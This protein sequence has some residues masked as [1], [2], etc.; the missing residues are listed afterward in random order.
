MTDALQA[1]EGA[2][3]RYYSRKISEF[4][5]TPRGV[6]WN[7]HESQQIRFHQ[8]AKIIG[9]A[10]QE[11]ILLNDLGCGYGAYYDYLNTLGIPLSYRGTDLSAGMIAAARNAHPGADNAQFEVKRTCA[12]LAHYS[13][14]SGVF[15]VRQMASVADW[16]AYVLSMLEELDSNSSRGFAFNCLSIYSDL[17]H[18]RADLYYGDPM[19]FFDHCKRHF[20]K[21]VALLHDYDLY[22]FTVLVRK[23]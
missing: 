15:N 22:E 4:G 21:N 16:H 7:S 11:P 5:A 19:F 17:D 9:E 10:G 20:A 13:V 6:D 3:E 1:L 2:T 14:A 23:S 8:L 12:G 18:Q